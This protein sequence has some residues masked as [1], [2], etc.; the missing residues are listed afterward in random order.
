MLA[1]LLQVMA[2]GS[3]QRV[4]FAGHGRWE[5]GWTP[6]KTPYPMPQVHSFTHM[7]TTTTHT[8]TL[9]HCHTASST[10]TPASHPSA[11]PRVLKRSLQG[12]PPVP[13]SPRRACTSP[14]TVVADAGKHPR[15]RTAR[16]TPGLSSAPPCA[17]ECYAQ[18]GIDDRNVLGD[19]LVSAQV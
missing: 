11:S 10:P 7:H 15:T 3:C 6:R 19:R 4:A 2:M 13:A 8:A 12:P 1:C 9:P 18:P 5:L 16:R 14:P 17:R